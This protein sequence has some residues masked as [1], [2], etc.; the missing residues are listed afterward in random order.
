MQCASFRGDH[1]SAS[2][3]SQ[4]F[5]A[6]SVLLR[7]VRVCFLWVTPSL[8]LQFSLRRFCEQTMAKTGEVFD[9]GKR[10]TADDERASPLC[11]PT[12]LHAWMRHQRDPVVHQW[13][14]H[15]P[16]IWWPDLIWSGLI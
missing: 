11:S 8:F 2:A 7:R 6:G 13:H 10:Y 4:R 12:I 3:E 15:T 5:A 9:A 16:T 1:G 14:V